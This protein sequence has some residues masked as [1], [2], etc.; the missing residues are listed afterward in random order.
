MPETGDELVY[1]MHREAAEH[2]R[3]QPLPEVRRPTIHY[4]ELP[5]AKPGDTLYHE[6]TT[7]CREVGRWLA[8]GHEGKWVLIK[9]ETVLGLYDT[10]QAARAEGLRRYLMES[11][12][13]HQIQT[14]E[15]VYRIRGFTF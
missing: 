7:Y 15:P 2:L 13:V 11:F 8:E 14:E 12:L 4:T 9:G 10:R 6:W 3:G 5:N 1:R